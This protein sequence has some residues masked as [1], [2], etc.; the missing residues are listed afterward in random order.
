MQP[1]NLTPQQLTFSSYKNHNTVKTLIAISP[2][3]S[4]CFVS[5]ETSRIN[6][7]RFLKLLEYGDSNK[8]DRGFIE[9]ILPPGVDLN[10]HTSIEQG[11]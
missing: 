5:E 7:S 6:E 2:P 9:N 10:V 8:A 11:N 1:A 3:G 4:I